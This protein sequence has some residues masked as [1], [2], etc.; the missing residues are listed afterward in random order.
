[1]ANELSVNVTGDREL[2]AMLERAQSRALP[3]TGAVV[4]KGALNVKTDWARRWSGL[5]HAPAI[6]R[7]VSYDVYHWPGSVNAEIGPDKSRR[8]GALGNLI[9][10]GSVNNAPV[11]GGIPALEAEAPKFERAL[12]DLGERLLS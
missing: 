7:A 3:E 10:Y 6:G 9:E 1:M 12:S 8:Q 2:L 4:T 11:P 5:K